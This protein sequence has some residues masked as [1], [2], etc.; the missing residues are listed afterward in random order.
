ML[1][2]SP[3]ATGG[4]SRHLLTVTVA[5]FNAWPVIICNFDNSAALIGRT[6]IPYQIWFSPY[7][8]TV[9]PRL[10]K[11]LTCGTCQDLYIPAMSLRIKLT[12]RS[13]VFEGFGA[14]NWFLTLL[15]LGHTVHC[16]RFIV[17]FC[18][19]AY[20]VDSTE[21]SQIDT[22]SYDRGYL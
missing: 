9:T 2:F 22:P 18:S 16:S 11:F 20:W 1:T 15:R 7:G 10:G 8:I 21:A 4:E 6:T 17:P 3:A 12:R 13:K 19:E 14:L 5:D